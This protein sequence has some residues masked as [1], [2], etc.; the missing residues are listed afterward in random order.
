[1]PPISVGPRMDENELVVQTDRYLSNRI[2]SVFHPTPG[3]IDRISDTFRNSIGIDPQSP[4][5]FP[6][7]ACPS[8]NLQEHSP[9][10]L[11]HEQIVQEY[12]LLQHPRG[13][14]PISGGID[15][16]SLKQVQLPFREDT[17]NQ[18]LSFAFV[19]RRLAVIRFEEIVA[20]G[21]L[22]EK[23]GAGCST[24]ICLSNLLNP[25]ATRSVISAGPTPRKVSEIRK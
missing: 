17:G 6:I 23:P 19:D 16:F 22:V 11:S 14:S 5:R 12:A 8:P 9:M 10:Q 2:G 4:R 15:I 24:P 7:Y 25:V 21:S 1:M 20:H 18:V 3:V 13:E